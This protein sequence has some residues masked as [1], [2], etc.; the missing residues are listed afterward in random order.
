MKDAELDALVE[1][2][3]TEAELC[4]HTVITGVGSDLWREG[5]ALIG[6]KFYAAADAIA[7]LREQHHTDGRVFQVQQGIMDSLREEAEELQAEVE[8]LTKDVQ[9]YRGAL[10]YP[11]PG[12]YSDRLQSGEIP[13]NGMAEALR[14]A[15]Q[16]ANN[17]YAVMLERD[18]N[19]YTEYEKLKDAAMKGGV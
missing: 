3:C 9:A 13:V 16:G 4:Q 17:A 8:A 7:A 6:K 2:I 12:D 18:R 5:I 1:S 14:E 10:G 15:L 11:V 19:L